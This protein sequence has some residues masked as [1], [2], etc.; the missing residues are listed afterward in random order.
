MSA[1]LNLN[2]LAM[3]IHNRCY[4]HTLRRGD[5][6]RL[7]GIIVGIGCD[8]TIGIRLSQHSAESVITHPARLVKVGLGRIDRRRILRERVKDLLQGQPATIMDRML[9]LEFAIIAVTEV[10]ET[11]AERIVIETLIELPTR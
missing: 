8:M 1:L 10:I 4:A 5:S 11:P 2:C 7:C 6:H 9:R 3:T